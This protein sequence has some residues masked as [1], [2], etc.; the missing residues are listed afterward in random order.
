M[1]IY[2]YQ[3]LSCGN[4]FQILVM[5]RDR[6]DS[7]VC[8]LCKGADIKKLISRAS[9]NISEKDRLES[10]DPRAEKDDSFYRD[11]RN[12]GLHAKKRAQQAGIDLGEE[13][14][15]RL[16]NIRSDPASVIK[17]GE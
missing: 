10:Y 16:D 5:E 14:E 2:E 4:N 1:P 13:F 6:E 11:S 15:K 17:K 9:F 3:C 7:P 8:P 12:I